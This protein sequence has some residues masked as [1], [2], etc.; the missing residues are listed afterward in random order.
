MSSHLPYA[1]PSTGKIIVLNWK[2]STGSSDLVQ[3]RLHSPADSKVLARNIE[4]V[5]ISLCYMQGIALFCGKKGIH[6]VDIEG[7]LL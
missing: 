4:A 2:I 6:H 3:L 1:Q 7:E 5:G